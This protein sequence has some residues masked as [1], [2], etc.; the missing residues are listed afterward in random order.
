MSFCA[1]LLLGCGVFG[2]VV[3]QLKASYINNEGFI[4]PQVGATAADDFISK[5]DGNYWVYTPG[6]NGDAGIAHTNSSTY[7]SPQTAA[8]NSNGV[9]AP[10]QMGYLYNSADIEQQFNVPVSGNYVLHY[11]LAG[12]QDNA[13]DTPLISQR[14]TVSLDTTQVGA[15]TPTSTDWIYFDKPLFLTAGD[16]SIDFHT[17]GSSPTLNYVSFVDEVYL[18]GTTVPEP[19]SLAVAGISGASLLMRRKR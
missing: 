19:A 10:P 18:K 12:P 3:P 5:P 4:R 7:S 8:L 14:V 13:S 11:A 17:S 15:Y 16:H 1:R 2:F 6:A 9:L